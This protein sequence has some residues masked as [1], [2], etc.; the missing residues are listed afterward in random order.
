M[1]SQRLILGSGLAILLVISAASIGLD[2][3]SR[4]EAQSLDRTLGVLKKISDMRPL[5]HAAE[6]AARGFALTGDATFAKEYQQASASLTSAF[7]NLIVAVKDNPDEARLLEEAKGQVDR[8]VAL[9]RELINLRNSGDEDGIEKLLVSGESRTQLEKISAALE[10]VVTEE[11]RQ[12]ALRSDR[13]KTNGSLLLA[14]D[15]LG[16]LL[17]LILAA[18][19]TAATRRSS[20]ELQNALSAAKTANLSLEAKVAERTKD[21][22][23]ALEEARRSTAVMETTFRSM[24][25]AVLVIDTTG[26]VLLANPA[27]EK[28]LRYRAGMTLQALRARSAVFQADGVTPMQVDDMP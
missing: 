28:I 6:S 27:A 13:S 7:G 10:H 21:L 15:L 12:L 2:V 22:G 1:A 18:M 23:A 26:G 25:E 5:L 24:A 3:K 14:I 16:A 17:I 19:M 20:R 9:G 8:E 11:R 4:D